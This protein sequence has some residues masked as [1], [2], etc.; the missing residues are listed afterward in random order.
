MNNYNYKIQKIIEYPNS[1]QEYFILENP[2]S[3]IKFNKIINHKKIMNAQI[4]SIGLKR[5]NYELNKEYEKYLL[6]REKFN[7]NEMIDTIHNDF[8]YTLESLINSD[9][10]YKRDV[11]RF[12]NG[13]IGRKRSIGER[14]L[15]KSTNTKE[16]I[17]YELMNSGLN[18]RGS[19][20]NFSIEI[21]SKNGRGRFLIIYFVEQ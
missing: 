15:Q 4:S 9:N 16:I 17:K 6:K 1:I 18:V 5:Y 13:N 3:F 10:V 19:N 11:Q 12:L 2:F 7:F 14:N 8:I 21:P 20:P